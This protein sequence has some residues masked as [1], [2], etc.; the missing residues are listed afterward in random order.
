MSNEFLS[1]GDRIIKDASTVGN[2]SALDDV[3]QTT[4]RFLDLARK[5]ANAEKSGELDVETAFPVSRSSNPDSS[6]LMASPF[7]FN[8]LFS[9]GIPSYTIP[10]TGAIAAPM[11]SFSPLERNPGGGYFS[12][13]L[14]YGLL[15]SS[16]TSSSS[17]SPTTLWDNPWLSYLISGPNSFASRLYVDCIELLVKSLKGETS[18]SGFVPSSLRYRFRYQNPDSL[19][20]TLARQLVRMKL[21]GH[22]GGSENDTV[23]DASFQPIRPNSINSALP[24][25]VVSSALTPNSPNAVYISESGLIIQ[26]QDLPTEARLPE[27]LPEGDGEALMIVSPTDYSRINEALSNLLMQIIRDVNLEGVKPGD[28]LDPWS[29]QQHICQEWGLELS[30]GSVRPTSKTIQILRELPN[31]RG[32]K[33]ATVGT[34]QEEP[35]LTHSQESHW[36]SV[37]DLLESDKIFNLTLPPQAS[38]RYTTL[39][40]AQN[41]EP[42]FA[43][44][45]VYTTTTA[46]S[47]P[48]SHFL[49]EVPALPSILL[50]QPAAM[51]SR[52]T[53]SRLSPSSQSLHS[54]P[55]ES[56]EQASEYI[57]R[58]TSST[59]PAPLIIQNSSSNKYSYQFQQ[60]DKTPILPEELPASPLVTALILRAICFGEGPRFQRPAVDDTVRNFLEAHSFMRVGAMRA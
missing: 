53:P 10:T 16:W 19:M 21:G 47:A 18:V 40:P 36:S 56:Y 42:Y 35:V 1:F 48:P 22:K 31:A 50:R 3:H 25:G 5:A 60:E 2:H 52:A 45:Y 29:V 15:S 34:N 9:T 11:S 43:Q 58:S 49:S 37:P 13:R 4:Q 57:S 6:L 39:F 14:N 38:Q 51:K 44:R 46:P 12:P 30:S 59:V 26:G 55:V 28:W 41:T 27:I 23:P 20:R 17:P 7:Q 8:A 54:G 24:T 32:Q 33:G